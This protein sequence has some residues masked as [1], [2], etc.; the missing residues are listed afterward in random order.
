MIVNA[1]RTRA[2]GVRRTI[3][4]IATPFLGI[5]LAP[6]LVATAATRAGAVPNPTV[7]GP[8]TAVCSPMC[9]SPPGP[10]NGIHIPDAFDGGSNLQEFIDADYVEEEFFFEGTATAFERDPGA[11]AW[12]T[13]GFWTARPSTT[14][15]PAAYKSRV[16]VHRPADPTKFNGIVVLEWFNETAGIDL[17]PDYGY[18]RTQLRREGAIFVGVS[19][20][21]VGINGGIP[22]GFALKSWDPV[23][24]GS[25]LHPGDNYCY[26]IFSQA[27]QAIRNPSGLSPIPADYH[28]TA[29]IADGESQSA[30][31]MVTYVDAIAPLAQVFDGYFI[32]S[33]GAAGSGL[34]SGAGGAVPSP[35]KIRSDVPPVLVFETETDTTGHFNARQ[36]DGPNYRLWEPAGT[37]HVD[38]YDFTFF[39][40]NA[41]TSEPSY[42]PTVCNFPNNMA[43]EH[44]V[45][46]AALYHLGNW[47]TGGA[48]PPNAPAPITVVSGA[49]QRDANNIALGGIR[50]PE[51]DVPIATHQGTGNTGSPFCVLFGRTIP[52][53]V[54]VSSLYPT[55]DAYVTAF[56]TATN[57]LLTAGFILPADAAETIAAAQSSSVGIACGNGAP[58]AG[59]ECDDGNVSPGDGCSD[60]CT[61]ETGYFCTGAPSMCAPICGDE[62]VTGPEQ[63]DDGNTVA[64]DGCSATCTVE[65]G[66][67]CMGNPSACVA[68][69]GDGLVVDGEVCDD[70]NTAGGD[71][72]GAECTVEMGW[73]CAGEPSMCAPIC[74]DGLVRGSEACDEGAANGTLPSCCAATCQFKSAGTTC[75]DGNA[76]TTADACDGG[77]G[78]V[79][80]P[81]PSCDDGNVCTADSCDTATGCVHDGPPRDG[82]ACDD[83][84]GC[85]QGDVCSNGQCAGTSGA[86]SDGDGYCDATE[87]AVGCNPN[88]A[89]EIPAQ[90]TTYGGGHSAGDIL[91]TYLAPADRKVARATDP[92][93]AA[94]G[95][96]AAN[97]F[98]TAGKIA[99]P[100]TANADCNLPANTCRVVANYGAAPDLTVRRPFLL[101]RTV[102]TSFEPLTPGCSRKVDL[103]MDT[104]RKSNKLKLRVSGTVGG[105]KRNDSDTF[106]YR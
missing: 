24:Y 62:L 75:D 44:Y 7:T 58:E 78:C 45:M 37:A 97:H 5:A 102:V 80:G 47:I 34:F 20:Q 21:A 10:A 51:M 83:H 95:A 16:L 29:M 60:T 91:V 98:C 54:P 41:A 1:F 40:Q 53:P 46:N 71:G 81:P 93:C 17:P 26:D 52:L 4:G 35:S 15:A 99:D 23:R 94:T 101:N 92:S 72:C 9:P 3:S 55:H 104:S 76:C 84:D 77:S 6:L 82:F 63:C 68:I 64:G 105:R 69:C 73:S 85:T 86:D 89:A 74:G 48:P 67:S 28:I 88:D 96:C 19:A 13:T 100:C 2:R 36:P 57:N 43:N 79:G 103:A 49:I 8:V 38:N 65:P 33:R 27:A 90:A 70:G 25:L 31:R 39:N 106:T 56:T 14:L 30:G 22:A 11:P 42:P 50:L 32:H 18:F 59:E 61:V 66:F 12:D 87:T